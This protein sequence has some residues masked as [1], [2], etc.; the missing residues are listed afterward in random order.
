MRIAVALTLLSLVVAA[1]LA[2]AQEAEPDR[3]E[4]ELTPE[5]LQA[6]LTAL[7]AQAELDDEAKAQG[8]AALEEAQA[9]LTKAAEA[10]QQADAFEQEA[11]AAPGLLTA[12]RAEL[13]TPPEPPVVEAPADATPAQIDPLVQRAEQELGT[14]REQ[15]ELLKREQTR[16]GERRAA[17]DLQIAAARQRLDELNDLLL[18]PSDAGLLG[19]ARRLKLLAQRRATRQGLRSLEA[20]LA[21]YDARRELLPA[22][23]DRAARRVTVAEKA[24]E[25]W[26]ERANEV[27]R[28]VAEAATREAERLR[29]EAA[30]K[31]A[32]MLEL[33]Q[34]N[35]RLAELRSG[36][37]Q[38]PGTT[39]TLQAADQQLGEIRALLK[40][41]RERD[42]LVRAK[43]DAA[44]LTNTMGLLLRKE[45][46]DLPALAPLRDR[47]RLRQDV[48][49]DLQY[50]M[51]VRAEE[52]SRVGDIEQRLVELLPQSGASADERADLERVGR[53]L[54]TQHRDLLTA[55]LADYEALFGRLIELDTA[56]KQVV[57]VTEG[58]RGYIEERILW[59]RSVTGDAAPD[60]GEA[61]QALAWLLRPEAWQTAFGNAL[62]ELRVR[63]LE[64]L[65]GV[66]LLL[67]LGS[68]RFWR[69]GTAP[70]PDGRVPEDAPFTE[71]L[72]A[73]GLLLVRATA[74]PGALY[75]VGWLLSTAPRQP[76]L[77]VAVGR[78]VQACA[79][80]LFAYELL[81]QTLLPRGLGQAHFG[82]SG[83]ACDYVRRHLRWFVPLKLVSI[84]LVT[85]LDVQ[86]QSDLWNDSLGRLGFVLGGLALAAFNQ[87]VLRP[88]GPALG[89]ALQA[90]PRGWAFRLRHV[91]YPLAV[92]LPLVLVLGAF[93]GYYYTAI[94][95][96]ARLETWLWLFLALIL[97]AA[98][99]DEWLRDARRRMAEGAPAPIDTSQGLVA[100]APEPIEPAAKEDPQAVGEG[101][102][103]TPA[104]A[105]DPA[106]APASVAAAADDDEDDEAAQAE[107]DA[108]LE[109]AVRARELLGIDL[110][111]KPDPNA[112]LTL[113]QQQAR[114]LFR[115]AVALVVILG[116][117][118]IWAD[119]LPAL[120]RLDQ[121]QIYPELR[122]VEVAVNGA[123][124][125]PVAAVVAGAVEVVT[126]AD[127]GLAIV[128]LVF[129]VVAAQNVPGLLEILIFSRLPLDPGGR[130]AAI[131]LARYTILLVGVPFALS[132][133]GISWESV[134]WLAAAF[135]FGLAFGLQEIFANFISGLIILL[136]RPVR[137]GDLVTV[138]GTSGV[139][140][141]IRMRATTI[142]DF[143]RKE[144]I[145]PNKQ[146]VTGSVL[147]WALSDEI[148]RAV[149]PISVA[150]GTK[151][152][153]AREIMLKAAQAH[154]LVISEPAPSC[155]FTG[156]GDSGLS[157]DLRVFVAKSK[158][159][160]TVQHDV[161]RTIYEALAKAK[162]EIPFPQRDLHL[163]SAKP[164][165]EALKR[166]V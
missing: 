80:A 93:R 138:A 51:I 2:R 83:P 81:R 75:A 4:A 157:F 99:F 44:G 79:V 74:L 161:L 125:A 156:L 111:A 53:E 15:F 116:T 69:I 23:L 12:I 34:E 127:L 78:G 97:A 148:I 104:E 91:W 136:E 140:S 154:P 86:R 33:A 29:L 123:E 30:R 46:E 55:L 72:I 19:E 16:R 98:L 160:M 92:G 166:G 90:N 134:Q 43:V 88:T 3:L 121:V 18:V 102:A 117:Y 87:R 6:R 145:V 1:P 149:I 96:E 35:K 39:A 118:L 25:A 76:E 163:R 126:L 158:D 17:L 26:R 20:E 32:A 164:L 159:K 54:L 107:L 59:V 52:R 14:A 132:R 49:A 89:A 94:R 40:T 10:S 152:E 5:G 115:S 50:Q 103:E 41:V 57:E 141:R 165:V 70:G 101:D 24:L 130:Y 38:A 147:N 71:T 150:Y 37:P 131:T 105:R 11:A 28:Q 64:G 155:F 124:A 22:R 73:A 7:E 106:A 162:I 112:E 142:T 31:S 36:T 82:W 58:F 45:L 47:I 95:L 109:A 120:R 27:R 66:L 128:M 9:E 48:L 137:V 114:Q 144:L 77:A 65:L 139:V 60:L 129:T 153:R 84:G 146:F 143:D 110:K 100:I 122:M 8:R 56:T 61:R 42:E 13:A 85:T 135:T 113:I 62:G 68:S 133:V 63:W 67:V 108:E 21:N 151:V 119:V